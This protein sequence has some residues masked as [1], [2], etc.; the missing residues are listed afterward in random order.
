VLGGNKFTFPPQFGR[1]D[2][3]YGHVLLNQGNGKMDYVEN[4]QSGLRVRGEV[5]VIRS[6][7]VNN[8]TCLLFAVNNEKPALYKLSN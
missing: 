7:R 1:L 2:G 3:S 4:R 8:K 6:I 5:K